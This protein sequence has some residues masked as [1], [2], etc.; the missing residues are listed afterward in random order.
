MKRI[1]IS[2]VILFCCAL[3]FTMEYSII[4]TAEQKYSNQINAI[5]QLVEQD[6]K[7]EAKVK[8]RKMIEEWDQTAINMDYF[9]SH[10][11][12]KEITK[13]FITMSE[14]LD[15]ETLD[16]Y[17]ESG[18]QIKKQLQVLKHCELPHLHNII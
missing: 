16:E 4:S 1:W 11:K 15:H 12:T 2:V 10:D 7:E 17:Y 8:C 9:I 13:Y 6:K 14:F 18:M 5:N 3:L